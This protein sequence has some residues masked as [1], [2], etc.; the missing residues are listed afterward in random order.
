MS[1]R[2]WACCPTRSKQVARVLLRQR[3]GPGRDCIKSFDRQQRE[4]MSDTKLSVD[5]GNPRQSQ[6]PL[7][8]KLFGVC[9]EESRRGS[10]GRRGAKPGKVCRADWATS[11]RKKLSQGG[12][13]WGCGCVYLASGVF[14]TSRIL[15]TWSPG[16]NG[17]WVKFLPGSC[18]GCETRLPDF[19]HFPRKYRRLRAQGC[20]DA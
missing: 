8:T 19:R 17:F 1:R 13:V 16:P 9:A 3:I 14:K 6:K 7:R 12:L 5:G 10:W 18:E 2:R 4:L 11:N 20:P 15:R